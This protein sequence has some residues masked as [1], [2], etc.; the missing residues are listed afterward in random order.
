[1]RQKFKPY[2]DY[3]GEKLGRWNIKDVLKNDNGLICFLCDCDCGKK[4][5]LKSC[6]ILVRGGSKSCGCEKSQYQK[7]SGQN[8][9]RYKGY[10]DIPSQY[11]TMLKSSAKIRN[12]CFNITI[13]YI[14]DLYLH[15]DKK[16][17]YTQLELTFPVGKGRTTSYSNYTA[18]LDRIDNNKGY[19]IGNVQWV[20]K[21]VNLIK[22]R[23]TEEFFLYIC[24]LIAK[25]NPIETNKDFNKIER[26]FRYGRTPTRKIL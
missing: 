16:C 6:C 13:E 14:W 20:H 19:E 9:V 17:K 23:Y 10:K 15:Q 11:F 2:K 21:D 3:I 5:L 25:Y 1:M 4:D 7:T 22:Q 24:N 26:G 12:L 8:S 18:S